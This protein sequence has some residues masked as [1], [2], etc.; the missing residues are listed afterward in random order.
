VL[1]DVWA[2]NARRNADEPMRL[3]LSAVAARLDAARRRVAARDAGRPAH[4]PAAYADA[5][6]FERDLRLVR[7]YLAGAAA[8]EAARANVDPLLAQVRAHGFHGFLLDVRDHADAH[9]EALAEVAAAVG[10]PELDAARC[11]ASS[12]AAAAHRPRAAAGRR[13]APVLDTFRAVRVVQDEAGEAAAGT[14][15]VSMTRGPRTCCACSCWRA[16]PARGPR[17]RPAA[18]AARRGAAVRDARRP[19]AR[20]EV[21]RALFADPAYARQLAARGGGRR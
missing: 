20:P 16:R 1:P 2:A 5:A 13:G 4:E 11:G 3:K 15:V 19:G 6:A 18:L 8:H 14:Y 9:R 17:R 7:G 10:C 21:M 12:P